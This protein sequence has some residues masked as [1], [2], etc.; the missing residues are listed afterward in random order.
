MD[1]LQRLQEWYAAQ[2]N[3]D[4]EHEFG[5]DIGTLDNPGWSLSVDLTGTAW[6]DASFTEVSD[7]ASETEW[8]SC[9]VKKRRFE[10]RCGPRML[11]EMLLVFLRWADAVR[12]SQGSDKKPAAT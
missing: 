3:G 1:T 12:E 2:C 4:W 7:L 9:K 5:I 10:G 8:I 6:E 11:E